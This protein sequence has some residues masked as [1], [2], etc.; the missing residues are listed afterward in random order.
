MNAQ[1]EKYFTPVQ[2]L[3]SLTVENVEKLVNLQVKRIQDNAQFSLDQI[4]AA[5]T[6]KDVDGLKSYLAD[7][8]DSMR[9]L[10]ERTVEDVRTVF[11][12]GNAFTTEAQRIFQDAF[13]AK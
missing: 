3:N 11:E 1:V 5:S 7:Y 10:S 4:K 13:K 2:E 9:Q 6:V 12:L 8:A